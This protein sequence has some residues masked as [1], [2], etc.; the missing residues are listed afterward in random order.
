MEVFEREVKSPSLRSQMFDHYQTLKVK[1]QELEEAELS[2]N[3]KRYVVDYTGE[4]FLRLLRKQYS[5]Q[6][7]YVDFW[8]TWCSP[9]FEDMKLVEPI[10]QHFSD[11][12]V[13]FV[14]LCSNSNETSWN[15]RLKEFD[16]EGEHYFLTNRLTTDLYKRFE[17]TGIPRYLLIDKSGNIVNEHAP[18]PSDKKQLIDQIEALL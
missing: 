4:E 17:I 1:D 7:L 12:D 9:C 10:K 6:V 14:Y 2:S 16:P 18:R 8:A 5:G 3:I 15:K 13:T 11:K